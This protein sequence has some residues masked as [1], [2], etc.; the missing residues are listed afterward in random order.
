AN[1]VALSYYTPKESI[2]K[3]FSLNRMA[4]NLGFSV[5]PA[6][7][8]FLAGIS[9]DWLFYGNALGGFLASCLF[10]YYFRRR[11]PRVKPEKVKVK[12]ES[13]YKNLRMVGFMILCALYAVCFFQLLSTLPL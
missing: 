8:G 12:V 4:V 2:T 13:P 6:L 10:V 9:Y 1:S 7:G 11:T 3:A 5:G